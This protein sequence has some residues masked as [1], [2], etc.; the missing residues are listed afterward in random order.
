MARSTYEGTRLHLNGKRPFNLTRSGY[1]GIQR[2]AALWT[3][4][5]GS[6][7]E[8][9]MLG[10]RLVN[11]LGLC[12]VAF[13]GYD[14]GGF[15]G[16][17]SP[18]LFARWISIGAFSPFCRVHTM[19]NSR[20]SEPWSYGEEVEII[21]RNYLRM[22]Y[23]LM[24]YIYTLFHEASVSGM[25]VQRSL[26][27]SYPH[28]P[29]VFDGT[30]ENEYMFGPDILVIPVESHKDLVKVY[31][32]EGEWYNLNDGERYSGGNIRAMECPVHRLPVYVRAG[33]VIP[34]QDPVAHTGIQSETL[35]LHIYRGGDGTVFNWYTD[36]GQTYD[37]EKGAYCLRTI[38]F[39]GNDQLSITAAEGTHRP[40]F[41]RIRFVLHGFDPAVKVSIN[42]VHTVVESEINRFFQPME[43]FDPLGDASEVGS[44]PVLTASCAYTP[45]AL[46]IVLIKR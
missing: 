32:P 34:M 16:E 35:H 12:G 20:D 22:R 33:A 26:A 37:F 14:I 29:E 2:Y 8:H 15:V 40:S 42:G 45:D 24:P 31:F 19:I 7:D 27:I 28:Q 23:Q 18:R 25:P 3:G 43:K 46:K 21:S 6:Y 30:F 39:N 11:S 44:E 17:A 10:I 38:A 41:S 13:S 9:M 5:N 4:D 1:A 36:D